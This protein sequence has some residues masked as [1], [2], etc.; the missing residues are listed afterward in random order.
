[1]T[2]RKKLL[3]ALGVVVALAAALVA[4]LIVRAGDR[5]TPPRPL[6]VPAPV[7]EFEVDMDYALRALSDFIRIDT[8]TPPG[9]PRDPSPPAAL[10]H[11]LDRYVVPMGLPYEVIE[12]RMLVVTVAGEDPGLAPLVLLSHYDVV[13]VAEDEVDDWTHPPFGGVVAD[14]YLWGR[15]AMDNKGSTICQLEAIRALR[16]LGRRPRREVR[17]VIVPDEEI[18]GV[19]GSGAIV[20]RHR[21]V[22]GDPFLVLDEG[23]ALLTHVF[24][25]LLL[26][27][28]AVGEKRFVTLELSVT[29]VPGHSSMPRRDAAPNV[30]SRALGRLADYQGPIRVLPTTEAFLDRVADH[31]P[32]ARRIPLKNRWLFEGAIVNQ[33]ASRPGPNATIRD[34]LA[35]TIFDGGVK[36][37]VI[38]A[39]VKA[40]VNMRLLPGS[41]LDEVLRRI[42]G[43][44]AEPRVQI[45]VVTDWGDTPVQPTTGE[46]W[47]R[48]ESALVTIFPDA[49][50]VPLVT[51]GTTDARYFA[52]ADIPTFRFLPFTVDDDELSRVHGIDERISVDNVR[53]GVRAYAMMMSIL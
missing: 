11:L 19:E 32:L 9:V 26:A 7:A 34:T 35:I 51:P 15:G 31:L 41:D 5:R 4:V 43:V 44:I 39:E 2:R 53:Q 25:G 45:E 52:Q 38:P 49:V 18:G 50:V 24:P 27:G 28:V 10:T 3:R 29:G 13:P 17:L 21:E 20:S 36:D 37:N 8:S 1:M 23:S 46:R 47:D 12:D 16:G 22:L 40:T 33:L 48:F 30:L 6:D 14:G 42:E